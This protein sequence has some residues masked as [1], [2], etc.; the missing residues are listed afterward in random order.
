MQANKHL[1]STHHNLNKQYQRKGTKQSAQAQCK[2]HLNLK[3]IHYLVRGD[4]VGC[5][6][7]RKSWLICSEMLCVSWEGGPV[8]NLGEQRG[9]KSI[10]GTILSASLYIDGMKTNQKIPRWGLS[11]EDLRFLL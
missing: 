5:V 7:F 2:D 1:K 3:S 9:G 11:E 8:L 4:A 10:L 6:Y